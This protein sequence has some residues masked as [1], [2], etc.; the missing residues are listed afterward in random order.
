VRP[1]VGAAAA[2]E[3]GERGLTMGQRRR[4]ANPDDGIASVREFLRH[5]L[6]KAATVAGCNPVTEVEWA[7]D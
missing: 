5:L 6:W 7:A 1:D 3:R 2:A 4:T